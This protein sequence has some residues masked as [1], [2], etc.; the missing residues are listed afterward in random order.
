MNCPTPPSPGLAPGSGETCTA[1]GPYTVTQA[2]VDAGAVEDTATAG[3]VDLLGVSSP[4]ASGSLVVPAEP[5]NPELSLAKHGTVT[6]AADQDD[7]RVGDT[8]NYSYVVTNTGDVT[9]T[10][11][12][13]VDPT[14]G[15][16]TCPAPAP[17]GLAP[18]ASATCTADDPYTVVQADIDNG[19][20]TDQATATGADANG[21][22]TSSATASDT[23]PSNPDPKVSMVKT[24]TVTPAADQHGA[25]IGDKISYSF[26][27]TNTGNVD[28]TSVAVTDTSLGAVSC[29]IP[30][31]PG[32]APGASETCTGEL[33]HIVSLGDEAAGSVTNTATATGTDGL[34]D[35]SP[36]SAPSTGTVPVQQPPKP[37]SPPSPP[38]P[39]TP[40][41]PAQAATKLLLHKQVNKANAYPGQKLTYTL[42]VT[43]EGPTTATDVKITDTPTIAIKIVSIHAGQGHCSA[44]RTITCTLGTLPVAHTV[45]IVIVAEAK[46]SGVE[47]NTATATSAEKLLDPQDATSTAT[48]KVTPILQVHKTASVHRATTGQNVTYKIA[49]TNPTLVAIRKVAVCDALPNGLFYVRASPTANVRTGAPCWT[50]ARLAAGQ[51]KRFTVVANVGPGT[52]GKRVNRASASAPGA[53]TGRATASVTVTRA[54]QVPC[55]GASEAAGAG[56]GRLTPH[57]PIAIIAC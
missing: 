13:V 12:A 44:G 26:V 8:I 56:R 20:A 27:V 50:I 1:A 21:S 2:D 36:A 24:A 40:P 5:A 45:K 22:S 30:A 16:V 53:R 52:A 54:P 15:S 14:L 47:R 37:P 31:P 51:T 43:D 18:G 4:S 23:N 3:G 10:S 41:T 28:L 32:L 11:F 6:P 49:V 46:G 9:L 29:P 39:P 19:G 55:A 34:G 57:A 38:S 33:D 25:Q 35:T 7:I 42:N 17:P 48:T